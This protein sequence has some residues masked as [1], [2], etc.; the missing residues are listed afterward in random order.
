MKSLRP[1]V[2]KLASLKRTR[3]LKESRS[4]GKTIV[5][6]SENDRSTMQLVET[7]PYG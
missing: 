4:V 7:D 2:N 1:E 3:A 6:T 5:R